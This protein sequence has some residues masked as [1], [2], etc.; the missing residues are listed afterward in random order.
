MTNA[1]FVEVQKKVVLDKG[2]VGVEERASRMEDDKHGF[3]KRALSKD[4][5][6]L[7]SK[8]KVALELRVASWCR[9][10]DIAPSNA[11]K[12]DE[13]AAKTRM[14]PEKRTEAHSKDGTSKT[15]RVGR[16]QKRLERQG[17]P[18]LARHRPPPA[19]LLHSHGNPT[20]FSS[21]TSSNG[22]RTPLFAKSDVFAITLVSRSAPLDGTLAGSM[23]MDEEKKGGIFKCY[24]CTKARSEQVHPVEAQVQLL[25]AAEILPPLTYYSSGGGTYLSTS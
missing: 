19:Q 6:N 21:I 20:S 22:P 12:D 23:T 15:A 7:P 8:G 9:G 24:T 1:T 10:A 4:K 2:I 14:H 16:S 3:S 11:E 25:E 5:R 18:S 17:K 13:I